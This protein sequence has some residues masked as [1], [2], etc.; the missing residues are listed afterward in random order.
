MKIIHII[1]KGEMFTVN[2]QDQIGRPGRVTPSDTWKLV[3]AVEYRFGRVSKT[4]T[5]AEVRER[6]V[7]WH[8]KNGKQRCYVMDY[9][10]GTRRV[11]MSPGLIDVMVT[12]EPAPTPRVVVETLPL[13]DEK[14]FGSLSYQIARERGANTSYDERD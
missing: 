8:Y 14:E 13:D 4:Y 3:G 9:D 5:A 2:E 6:Q 10:H 1:T 11:W 12:D 7:P